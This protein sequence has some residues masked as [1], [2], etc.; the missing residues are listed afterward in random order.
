MKMNF[1]VAN[2]LPLF[3]EVQMGSPFPSHC[4]DCGNPGGMCKPKQR[5]FK[6]FMATMPHMPYESLV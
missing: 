6:F 2:Y 1:S 4:F 3:N 5:D